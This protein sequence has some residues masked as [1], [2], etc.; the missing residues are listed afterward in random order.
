MKEGSHC[1]PKLG[2]FV[3]RPKG[4]GVSKEWTGPRSPG[5]VAFEEVHMYRGAAVVLLSA[6]MV[7]TACGTATRPPVA[8]TGVVDGGGSDPTSA[9][10]SACRDTSTDG[11]STVMVD[12][13]DF[14]Q[15]HGVQYVAADRQ[16]SPQSV[17]PQELGAVVGRITCML[18]AL[19]FTK[20]PGPAVDGDA[21]FLPVGTEVHAIRG[22]PPSCRVT[23]K[24]QGVNRVYVAMTDPGDSTSAASCIER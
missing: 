24:H 7:L 20:Q 2:S 19:K 10:Q 3:Q 17:S 21:A 18:S 11:V 6:A 15:L 12:W 8:G 13:V 14:L 1:Q 4:V 9:S 23:A 16:G 22:M 5:A